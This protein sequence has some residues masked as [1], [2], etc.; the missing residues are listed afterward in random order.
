[1]ADEIGKRDDNFTPVSLGVTNNAAKEIR[2]LRVN[3]ASGGLDVNIVG[4]GSNVNGA[5]LTT[6]IFD[7]VNS[8]GHGTATYASA[9]TFTVSGHNFTP[10]SRTLVKVDRFNSSGVYQ[11][12]IN[13]E[14]NTISV[15]T[16][17]G[18]STYTY[19]SGAFASG[20]LFVVYQL[21]PERTVTNASNSQR[22]EEINPITSQVIEESL[23]DTTN[24]AAS[25]QYYPSALGMA[26]MGYKDFSITGKYIDGDSTVSVIMV[27]ATNDED[28]TNAD[29]VAIQGQIQGITGAVTGTSGTLAVGLF[30]TNIT[31]STAQTVTFAW[32]FDNLNYRFVR[33][34][35]LPGDA[36]NTAI[37]KA[38]R[39][40]N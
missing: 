10:N 38:R 2:M 20:D 6:Y 8:F 5:G 16:T 9:T 37:I 3:A 34:G 26:M 17:A 13:P 35:L 27:Q 40:A 11:E 14:Q 12:T 36:T 28:A 33:V 4:S 21:G 19:S 39:K 32:E 7:A 15:S 18:V 30:T 1:M 22:T 29:W 25:Q 23:V 24:V 31:S